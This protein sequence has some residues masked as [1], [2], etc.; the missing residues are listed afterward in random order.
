M[1]P[2]SHAI[3][4]VRHFLG[5]LQQAQAEGLHVRLGPGGRSLVVTDGQGY[6]GGSGAA[7][8][9]REQQAVAGRLNE[10]VTQQVWSLFYGTGTEAGRSLLRREARL[11]SN[12]FEAPVSKHSP[13]EL[14]SLQGLAYSKLVEGSPGFLQELQGSLAELERYA[15]QAGLGGLA[16]FARR[17]SHALSDSAS[18]P[19]ALLAR[20]VE[21]VLPLINEFGYLGSVSGGGQDAR[22]REMM[23]KL[24]RAMML[25][26]GPLDDAARLEDLDADEASRRQ[27]EHGLDNLRL[28]RAKTLS[29]ADA[30]RMIA[31]QEGRHLLEQHLD[32][33]MIAA[34]TALR[35]TAPT[36]DEDS[37]K[38]HSE[39]GRAQDRLTSRGCGQADAQRWEAAM[40][41]AEAHRKELEE[42]SQQHEVQQGGETSPMRSLFDRFSDV[43]Q[44]LQQWLKGAEGPK[45]EG[46][47]SAAHQADSGETRTDRSQAGERGPIHARDGWR[48]PQWTEAAAEA[49]HVKSGQQVRQDLD[50]LADQM[51]RTLDDALPA[52]MGLVRQMAPSASPGA[53][54]AGL[55]PASGNPDGDGDRYRA[56]A[57]AYALALSEME[58]VHRLSSR[59]RLRAACQHIVPHLGALDRLMA[60]AAAMDDYKTVERLFALRK[61]LMQ[62]HGSVQPPYLAFQMVPLP[63]ELFREIGRCAAASALGVSSSSA[64]TAELPGQR[65]ALELMKASGDVLLKTVKALLALLQGADAGALA[66]RG[67]GPVLNVEMPRLG[68][69]TLNG[70]AGSAASP[71]ALRLAH[72]LLQAIEPEIRFALSSTASSQE[73]ALL[74]ALLT[75]LVQTSGSAAADR[76][77]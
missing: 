43:R 37:R 12:E 67:Y 62:A 17:S 41:I 27:V 39:L 70:Q 23:E 22:F 73:Q 59:D 72:A 33:A 6:R 4:D 40:A 42:R 1:K 35:E 36:P 9:R 20:M 52:I 71:E 38:L 16:D 2:V 44:A 56:L 25:A 30:A 21:D 45:G 46:G 65:S 76:V 60:A 49:G 66:S 47:D 63:P 58:Y 74:H 14:R 69:E 53:V 34:K 24:A 77:R 61:C 50:Q 64:D 10:L 18:T 3:T 7:Q 48:A 5:V 31:T 26:A 13:S 28:D 68:G 29:R 11:R 54:R 51:S 8:A 75:V 19:Q 32:Q 55:H 15:N 57:A